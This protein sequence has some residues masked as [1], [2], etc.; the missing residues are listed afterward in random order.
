MIAS[1]APFAHVKNAPS[2]T[3]RDAPII[4]EPITNETRL[5]ATLSRAQECSISRGSVALENVP[6]KQAAQ[7][8]RSECRLQKWMFAF[9]LHSGFLLLRL[10]G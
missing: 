2:D 6:N 5:P 9:L 7:H 3:L 4:R 10:P 1:Y 8:L